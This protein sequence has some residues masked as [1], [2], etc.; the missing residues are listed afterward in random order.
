MRESAV[1]GP[2]VEVQICNAGID[3][4]ATFERKKASAF[5]ALRLSVFG[6]GGRI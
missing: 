6:C 2:A 4:G 3:P 1:I 5:L